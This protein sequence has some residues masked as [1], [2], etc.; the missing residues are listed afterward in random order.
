M[1]NLTIQRNKSFVASLMKMKVYVEDYNRF[2]TAIGDVPCRFL[3]D[4]KNGE[5]K[6]FQVGEEA[7]RVYVIT[8]Q[9]SKGICNEYYNLPAGTE[10]VTLTGQNRYNP[11]NGNAFRFDGVTDKD[12]LKNRKKG[13]KKG[14]LILIAAALAGVVIG[15]VSVLDFGKLFEKP[16][17]FS[18]NGFSI[19][20][21]SRF[22]EES[23]TGLYTVVFSTDDVLVMAQRMG[24][25]SDESM[26]YLTLEQYGQTLIQACSLSEDTTLQQDGDLYYFVYEDVLDGD[27]C[28]YVTYVYRTDDAFWFVD[29]VTFTE[30]ADRY[31]TQ[32]SEW[33]KSVV[34]E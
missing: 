32:I 26:N 8:D 27:S 17:A 24:F 5:S 34:L 30:D 1:R 10:D 29:F 15:L 22:T 9:L 31:R 3:G 14:I 16:E 13:N 20:L 33:A 6:T 21:T 18:D 23:D 7:A 25:E 19:T 28:T 2:D 12:V 11:A 4:L